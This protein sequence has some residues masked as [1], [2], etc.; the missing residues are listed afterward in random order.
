MRLANLYK[1]YLLDIEKN[2]STNDIFSIQQLMNS[3][4]MFGYDSIDDE[5]LLWKS[6]QNVQMGV[7]G[8]LEVFTYKQFIR[9]KRLSELLDK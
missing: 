5:L 6:H 2:N 1:D 3:P 4:E 9:E 8:K 7:N